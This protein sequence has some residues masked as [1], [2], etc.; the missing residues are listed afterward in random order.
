MAYFIT[1]EIISSEKLN[2]VAHA[3]QSDAKVEFLP[4][5]LRDML[6]TYFSWFTIAFFLHHK[7]IFLGVNFHDHLVSWFEGEVSF[8]VVGLL[9]ATRVD[10]TVGSWDEESV[11]GVVFFFRDSIT[12][13]FILFL[14][15]DGLVTETQLDNGGTHLSCYFEPDLIIFVFQDRLV[16][17]YCFAVFIVFNFGYLLFL[18]QNNGVA[19][20]SR[21]DTFWVEEKKWEL[22]FWSPDQQ[23]W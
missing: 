4:F 22:Y 14:G 6:Q 10:E 21:T 19:I 18:V 20:I 11:I 7:P 3:A 1:I 8:G 13:E 15:D 23:Q 9:I 16:Q 2:F 17:Q 5:C 12:L